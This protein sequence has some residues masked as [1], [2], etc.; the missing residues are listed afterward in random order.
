MKRATLILIL[1]GAPVMGACDAPNQPDPRVTPRQPSTQLVLGDLK[2]PGSVTQGAAAAFTLA[3]EAPQ[4]FA[5]ASATVDG[6]PLTGNISVNYQGSTMIATMSVETG[7]LA[8]GTHTV[9]VI[10]RDLSGG[11][12]SASANFEVIAAA[13]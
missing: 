9:S 13:N 6:G 4:G 12:Q 2:G 8:P 10:V 3:I 1:L 11:S 7:T 5:S